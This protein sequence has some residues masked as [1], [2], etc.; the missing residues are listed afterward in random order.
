MLLE[1]VGPALEGHLPLEQKAAIVGMIATVQRST[2]GHIDQL[3]RLGVADRRPDRLAARLDAIVTRAL[4]MA[5][6]PPPEHAALH[7][8]VDQMAHLC[9]AV[10]TSAIPATLIHGDLHTG[11]MTLRGG[12]LTVFDWAE[13]CISHPFLD[14][15]TIFN[16]E[17]VAR[18]SALRNAYLA[19]WGDC[20][21]IERLHE[22]W[23]MAGVVHALHH[24]E[25]YV[26][27][28]EHTE[29]QARDEVGGAIPFL[30]CKAERY[31]A[32]LDQLDR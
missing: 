19:P 30:L 12:A 29:A 21:P 18:R 22:L 13:A 1:D 15:F 9:A 17:D 31:L 27:I 7:G 3:R 2:T 14:M 4:A 26:S 11:N 23:A 6:L 5:Q 32:E 24:L 16:E 20:E 25:S 10:T 8:H 28:L